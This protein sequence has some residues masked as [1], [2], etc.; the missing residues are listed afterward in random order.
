MTTTVRSL[1]LVTTA[2]AA[3]LTGLIGCSTQG[4]PQAVA[5]ASDAEKAVLIDRVKS[6]EGEWEMVDDQ[7]QR[8]VASV[9]KV[10]SGGSAVREVMFP[11]SDHEMTNVYHMDGPTLVLTHYCAVGNQPRMRAVAG[12]PNR[13]EFRFD[14]VTNWAGGGQTYMGQMTLEFVDADHIVERWYHIRDGQAGD[15]TEFVLTRKRS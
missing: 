10:G 15:P 6:L 3:I 5:A 7:G 9:F 8:R 12:S 1:I 13:I 14:S 2:S 11:G 4:R